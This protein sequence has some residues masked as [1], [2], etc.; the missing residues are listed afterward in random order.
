MRAY[1]LLLTLIVP[2]LSLAIDATGQSKITVGPNVHVSQPHSNY[3]LGEV[4]LSADPVDSN[5]L[6][7]CAI[8]YSES[9]NRQ[10]TVVYLSTDGGRSWQPTLDTKRFLFSG[11][12]ACAMGQNSSAYFTAIGVEEKRYGLGIYSS[13]DGGK[14][15]LQREDMLMDFQGIDRESITV[16]TTQSK[17]KNRIYITGESDSRYLEGTLRNAFAVWPSRDGGAS[18]AGPLKREATINHCVIETGNSV[19]LSDG[20]LVSVFGDAKILKDCTIPSST[21]RESNAV[22]EAVTT[23]A[24]GD[25]I[26]EAVKIDDFFMAWGSEDRG[27]STLGM[28]TI[29]VDSGDGPFRD[30]L[31]V[32]WADER[33]GRSEIRLSYSADKGVTWS[34]SSVIDDVS[35]PLDYKKAPENF[36]PTVAVNRVGVV[37]VTWYDRRDSPDGLGWYVR[38]RASLDGGETWLPSVRVSEKANTFSADQKLFSFAN[39]ERPKGN[40]NTPQGPSE[41]SSSRTA[42]S[43][44]SGRPTHVSI[45]VDGRAFYAGDYA[46][47]AADAGGTFHALWIDDR[48]GLPQVWTAP[49]V[50]AGIAQRNGA[51]ELAEFQ[52]V[53]GDVELKIL[54]SNYD[55]ATKTVTIRVCLKNASKD[56][57][58]GPV[59]L[60]LLNIN[61]SIGTPSPVN[62]DN[63]LTQPGAVW[64]LSSLLKDNLLKPNETS[65]AKD[66]VFRLDN[67]VE[68]LDGKTTR[69]RLVDLDVRVLAKNVHP[70]IESKAAH[71]VQ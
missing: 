67:P 57:I 50:V 54:S 15:W 6:L 68:L 65:A 8:V 25:S 70:E 31:Y 49:I 11:D 20:T 32:T 33:N 35:G 26:S 52:D 66:L 3:M 58:Q 59:N 41:E 44:A 56:L 53:S 36:L 17:F 48:T 63:H 22:L 34:K 64:D 39:A 2:V 29:A 27:T 7:G 37:L 28:P 43:E 71:D 13:T 4:L 46:G 69:Y 62:P 16:D 14:T 21:P 18:F 30:R 40:T 38:T 9:D 10:W 51:P 42:R 55:R 60:R 24:G 12:P 47:L 45:V 61:S 5:R 23:I 1:K 19:V